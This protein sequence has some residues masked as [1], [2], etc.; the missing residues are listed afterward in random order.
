MDKQIFD[1]G[2]DPK[3]IADRLDLEVLQSLHGDLYAREK[4]GTYRKLYSIG[5]IRTV[6]T[7]DNPADLRI[8]IREEPE[9]GDSLGYFGE[10]YHTPAEAATH[11][12]LT[13]I[14]SDEKRAIALDG[15]GRK[16]SI[17]AAGNGPLGGCFDWATEAEMLKWQP[18]HIVPKPKTT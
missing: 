13:V 15:F 9:V 10:I 1:A 2:T 17:S 14:E 5:L 6:G 4:T 7:A 3:E 12:G 16:Y 18:Q 8:C 11:E